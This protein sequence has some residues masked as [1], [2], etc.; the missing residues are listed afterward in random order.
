MRAFRMAREEVLHTWLRYLKQVV[1]HF[2]ITIGKPVA[3][4]RI[5]QYRLPEGCWN[6]VR[7]F[8]DSL[9]RLPLW[10]N[11]DLSLTAFGGKRNYD[12]WQSVFE[13]GETPE[14]SKIMS[15]GIDLMDMIQERNG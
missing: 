9:S 11:R 7:N 1:H 3:E 8:V 15:S 2:F 4:E 14:G 5:L 10:V 13:T 6:N 12:Y